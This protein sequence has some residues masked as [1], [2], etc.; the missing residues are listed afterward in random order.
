MTPNKEFEYTKLK[1]GK[2]GMPTWDGLI[3][4][5]IELALTQ[6][7]WKSK[8]LQVVVSDYLNLPDRLRNLKSEKYP[9]DS[10]I[11][12]RVS[13][14]LSDSAI[15]G[16]FIRPKRGIYQVTELG[17]QLFNQYGYQLNAKIIHSQ[18]NYQA[19]LKE[20]KKRKLTGNNI[21][22]SNEKQPDQPLSSTVNAINEVEKTIFDHNQKIA[23]ELL[24]RI[25][26]ADPKFFEQLVVNLLVKMGYKGVNG[27]SIVT[28]STHDGGIDGVINQDAL[29]TSTVYIQ[30]KRYQA[31][32]IVQRPAIDAFYGALSREHADRGV[33]ITTSSFSE[34][35]KV[36]A[37][38]F[39]IVLID[40]LE[41]TDLMLQFQVGVQVKR[42][43]DLFT[44]DEDYF[45]IE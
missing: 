42:H 28:P 11:E 38:S 33:F 24:T 14:A 43:Y 17:K 5:T 27:T 7:E 6:K 13:W 45:E 19:H 26:E 25:R 34:Q 36:T 40:G 32:N 1:L 12:G 44:I 2:Y 31:A 22:A 37:K 15:A 41:L 30:A 3:G 20:L 10:V 4:V 35:A 16:L 29:G 8:E 18:P 9:D 21:V 39:S 23:D